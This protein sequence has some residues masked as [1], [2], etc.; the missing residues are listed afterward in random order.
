VLVSFN[1][2]VRESMTRHWFVPSFIKHTAPQPVD[3]PWS[4]VSGL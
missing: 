3:P 1:S 2:G 4:L